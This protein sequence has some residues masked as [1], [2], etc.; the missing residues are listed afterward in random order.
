MTHQGRLAGNLAPRWGRKTYRGLSAELV[1][2]PRSSGA[3]AISRGLA[4]G[5][6][7]VAIFVEELAVYGV[8]AIIGVDIAGS[9]DEKLR[10]GSVA[11][12]ETALVGDGTSPH[13]AAGS[14]M[15]TPD[16]DLSA[17]L[18]AALRTQGLDFSTA[19]VW[20]TDAP[21]RET[22]T[23]IRRFRDQGASLVDMET[24]ALFAS[25]G[26]LGIT[27]AS[28]LIVAD[29]LFDGWRPPSDMTGIQSRL[30]RAALAAV[31]CLRT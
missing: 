22:P 21:F 10:S 26:A 11:V 17:G 3:V 6:P 20:S 30:G 29:E 24:A 8:R 31:E 4:V 16:A 15:V 25:A 7:A 27:A 5:G 14:A 2:L 23:E 12:I 9:L 19:S 18:Q 1:T 13:Y 28:V